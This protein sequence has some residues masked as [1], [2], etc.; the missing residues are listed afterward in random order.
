MFDAVRKQLGNLGIRRC[1][2]PDRMHLWV[3]RE[4]AEAITRPLFTI[5][6][7]FWET[8]EVTEN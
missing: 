5:F 7:K 8:G 2:G 3:L 4:L 1:I 6:G